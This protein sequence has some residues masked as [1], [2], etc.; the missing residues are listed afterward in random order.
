MLGCLE[1]EAQVMGSES[2]DFG[3]W[4]S[5]AREARGVTMRFLADAAEISHAHVSKLESGVANPSKDMVKRLARVLYM[6]D[7]EPDGFARF[8]NNGLIAA[9]F[10]PESE[11]QDDDLR[12]IAKNYSGLPASGR[13]MLREQSEALRKLV[14]EAQGQDT[15]HGKKAE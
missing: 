11:E 14:Q 13:R 6:P 9:G 7:A 12:V 3:V 1:S 2:T 10:L 8:L 15:T 5:E 4:L